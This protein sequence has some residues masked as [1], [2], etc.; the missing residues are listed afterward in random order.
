MKYATQSNSLGGK[1]VPQFAKD[2]NMGV[3][4]VWNYIKLGRI[5]VVRIGDRITRIPYEEE[6]RIAREGI[7]A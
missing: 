3:S 5:R 6:A 4:T 1:P 2:W 7:G